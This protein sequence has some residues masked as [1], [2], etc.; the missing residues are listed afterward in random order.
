MRLDVLISYVLRTGLWFSVIIVSIGGALYLIQNG[1]QLIHY[2]ILE[3]ETAVTVMI[4][5]SELRTLSAKAIINLG[6]FVLVLTQVARVLLTVI[7]FIA[8]RDVI[9]ALISL[10]ILI[11]LIYSIFWRS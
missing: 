10:V 11:A 4:I 7:I 5:L 3:H 6:L 1:S 9:F 8:E 2:Q